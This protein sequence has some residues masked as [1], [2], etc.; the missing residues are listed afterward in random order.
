LSSLLAILEKGLPL[1]G[2][3][4]LARGAQQ[5]LDA[6]P[7]FQ[8]IEPAADD[9]RRHAF[10]AGSRRQAAASALPKRRLRS[11]SGGPFRYSK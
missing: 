10:D 6:E 5:Q 4:Q 9:G 7:G 2:N 3:G 11:A 8:R 1:E